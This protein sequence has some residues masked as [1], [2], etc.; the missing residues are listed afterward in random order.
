MQ[1]ITEQKCIF[2]RCAELFCRGRDKAEG[3]LKPSPTFLKG[4]LTNAYNC[5][6]VLMH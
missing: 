6:I 2:V 5:V 3:G 4:V 1:V